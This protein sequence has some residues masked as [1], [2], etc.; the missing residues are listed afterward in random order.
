MNTSYQTQVIIYYDP[1][2][3]NI[4]F[5]QDGKPTHGFA[6]SIAE[7]KFI[8]HL[9]T[10]AT[11][12]LINKEMERKKAKIKQ[13][14]A[15][16]ATRGLMDLKRDIVAQYG[17]KST[18]DLTESQLDEQIAILNQ[19]D[20]PAAIRAARSSVLHQ[21]GKLGITGSKEDGWGRVNNYLLQPRI[22]GKTLYQMDKKELEACARKLRAILNK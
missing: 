7:Q 11:I 8:E 19:T 5:I 16:L 15:I 9:D 21:L 22:A 6:G 10:G 2:A 12:I 13:F 20:T 1:A 4:M 18:K 14:N 3:R 17:V